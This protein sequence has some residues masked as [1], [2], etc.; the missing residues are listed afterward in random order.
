MTPTQQHGIPHRTCATGQVHERLLRTD[1]GYAAARSTIENLAMR[2]QVFPRV[3]RR[4]GT[5][6]IPVVVHVV[7]RTNTEDVSAAQVRSQLEVL[8]ADFRARND[9]LDAV[10]EVF[11]DLVGD[12]RVQFAL[13]E[14]DP[15]G[16]PT[17]G[18]VR[19][20]T[21]VQGFG[22]D[23]EV[24]SS[25]TGG[26]DPWPAHRYLNIWVCQLAGG[27]LGYAQ[28]PGG[29][30]ETD[31]VVVLHTAFGTSGTATAPFDGGRTTTHEVGHWLDLRHIWGDDGTGCTGSDEVT[32]TPNQGGP[33]TGTPTF[34]S[35]S[36]DNGPNGDLFMNYMDYVDDAAMMMFTQGQVTRMQAALTGPRASIG[37]TLPGDE[38]DE[39]TTALPDVPWIAP[40]PAPAARGVLPVGGGAGSLATEAL[41]AQMWQ[42]YALLAE[43]GLHAPVE[44]GVQQAEALYRDEMG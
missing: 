34:P 33:N 39:T 44:A 17:E 19:V 3:V 31:G 35:V 2:A 11:A 20:R 18:I 37:S 32:D 7:A 26:S 6:V 12:A 9:D 4:T 10:P 41:R 40:V 14:T 30:P 15:D 38:S 36:C 21:E 8:N 5:T 23:D 28:F 13:A 43:R 25:A 1:P 42:E 22:A 29:P 27:L 24:K 16:N